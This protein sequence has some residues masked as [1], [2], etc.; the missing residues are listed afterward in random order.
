LKFRENGEVAILVNAFEFSDKEGGQRFVD[1]AQVN[2]GKD[3][4]P[5]SLDFA[6]SKVVYFSPDVDKHQPLNFSN[7]PVIGPVKYGG[8]PIGLQIIVIELDRMTPSTRALLERLAELGKTA[9][10]AGNPVTDTLFELGKSMISASQDDIIFEYRMVMDNGD[11][12]GSRQVSAFQSGRLVFRRAQNRQSDFVWRNLILD[13]NTGALYVAGDDPSKE[14]APRRAT[15]Y[16]A[17]KAET[18]FT[19]NVINH[20]PLGPIGIYEN[21]TWADVSAAFDAYLAMVD[22]PAA[23]AAVEIGRLLEARRSLDASEVIARKIDEAL[24]RWRTYGFQTIRPLD[25]NETVEARVEAFP[26]YPKNPQGANAEE[27]LKLQSLCKEGYKTLLSGSVAAPVTRSQARTATLELLEQLK[28]HTTPPPNSAG[29]KPAPGATLRMAEFDI[30]IRRLWQ[31]A[32]SRLGI[33]VDDQTKNEADFQTGEQFK[34]RFLG[35]GSKIEELQKLLDKWAKELEPKTC[36]V[37][38]ARVPA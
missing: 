26:D 36:A 34:T 17:Y 10:G 23:T 32:I 33:S 37:V 38:R 6:N 20:G 3:G 16:G 28:T 9:A 30:A 2:P 1:L 24:N 25:T 5:G 11:Y 35:D 7:I 19:V 18:Y 22:T 8:R 31:G 14:T 29:L 21:K 27:T 13:Q 4:A 12:L 15:K